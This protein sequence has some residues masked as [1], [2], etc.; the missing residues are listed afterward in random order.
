MQQDNIR[1]KSLLI[2]SQSIERGKIQTH[3]TGL[4][5]ICPTLKYSVVWNFH[6]FCSAVFQTWAVCFNKG[7]PYQI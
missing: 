4:E 5:F 1:L 6:P 7:L 3:N 2:S